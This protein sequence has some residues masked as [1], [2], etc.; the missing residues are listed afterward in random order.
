[1]V[2]VVPEKVSVMGWDP[3]PTVSPDNPQSGFVAELGVSLSMV[4]PLVPVEPDQTEVP[5]KE[6]FFR[7]LSRVFQIT[8][9]DVMWISPP[10]LL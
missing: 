3:M 2:V 9:I 4:K 1:M 8:V 5:L 10:V 7:L 6:T